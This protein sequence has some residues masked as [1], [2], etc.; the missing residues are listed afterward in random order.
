MGST[1][2]DFKGWKYGVALVQFVSLLS[3]LFALFVAS[4]ALG[5]EQLV[6]NGLFAQGTENKPAYWTH[7]GYAKD[8]STTKFTWEVGADGLGAIAIENLRPNDAR[9]IQTVPVSPDTWYRISGW[10][11]T[12]G[13]GSAK[14]GAYL[15]V[16]GT[17]H[18]TKD[19]RGTQSWKPVSM[20]VRTGSLDTQIKLGAR[21]GGYSSENSGSA[22]F[23]GISVEEAGYPAL[24]TPYVY[25][26]KAGEVPEDNPF[27]VEILGLL[28]VIGVGLLIWRYVAGAE[29]RVPR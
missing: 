17:F 18:N 10:V 2:V 22:F 27:W 4:P 23:S 8:P 7:A 16:M 25:G 11:R 19:L 20:W 15:S 12:Q 1:Y 28:M 13:V 14:M 3:I 5:A 6:R 24:G 29:N 21:L 26:G 9:W